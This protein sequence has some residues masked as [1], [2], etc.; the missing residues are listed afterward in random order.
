MGR[1]IPTHIF[2]FFYWILFGLG[3]AIPAINRLI[4]TRLKR[5]FRLFTAPGTGGGVHLARASIV[6]AAAITV[7]LSPAAG[8]ASRT[9]F[10]LIGIA[11]GRKKFLLFGS[12]REGFSAI[13][14]CK[15]FFCESH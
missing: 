2:K 14:T 5:D 11:L 7:T 3:V 13:G 12:K 9:S 8:T 10:R 6:V 4:A 1:G 15:R